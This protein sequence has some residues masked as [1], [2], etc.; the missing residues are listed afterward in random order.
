MEEEKEG[1]GTNEEEWGEEKEMGAEEWEVEEELSELEEQGFNSL[2]D[3]IK[4]T[5]EPSPVLILAGFMFL[6][7]LP[8]LRTSVADH[9]RK[10]PVLPPATLVTGAQA[11]S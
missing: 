11:S 5:P 10:A 2:M 9:H 4:T 6:A 7:G 8:L 3:L 1:R